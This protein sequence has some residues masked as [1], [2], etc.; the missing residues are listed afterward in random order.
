MLKGP[1]IKNLFFILLFSLC[2]FSFAQNDFEGKIVM[3]ITDEESTDID[4]YLKK[5]K[6][7]M[8]FKSDEG[9][10]AIL[11]D[12][13]TSKTLMVMPEQKM[14]MEFPKIDFTEDEESSG[15][16]MPEIKMTGEK[17]VINGY[18]CEKWLIK[19][20]EYQVEA[21]MTDQLGSYFMMNS[22]MSG[23]PEN[24]WQKQLQGNFFPMFV[25]VME[26]GE[27]QTTM[28]V[29]SADKISLKDDLF[30]VP[31]DFQRLNMPNMDMF[32][33]D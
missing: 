29:V 32:K 2:S 9:V 27:K 19:D 15:N 26:N 21:W 17:K 3:R 25:T 20:D 10:M 31:S 5:D 6:M 30:N 22:P 1:G 13:K 16:K 7:R 14:Y 12:K 8:E 23:G 33:Q 4:Y 24:K 11:F 28:E 18:N